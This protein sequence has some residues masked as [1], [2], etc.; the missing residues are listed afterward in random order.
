MLQSGDIPQQSPEESVDDVEEELTPEES[1]RAQKML[2]MAVY[3][4]LGFGAGSKIFEDV[5][6]LDRVIGSLAVSGLIR[7]GAPMVGYGS[8]E[9]GRAG[10]RTVKATTSGVKSFGQNIINGTNS[11]ASSLLRGVGNRVGG[12]RRSVSETRQSVTDR[13]KAIKEVAGV[14]PR[15]LFAVLGPEYF[16]ILDELQAKRKSEADNVDSNNADLDNADSETVAVQT[17]DKIHFIASV[18]ENKTE[19]SDLTDSPDLLRMMSKPGGSLLKIASNFRKSDTQAQQEIRERSV[20]QDVVT[21][22][23]V[24]IFSHLLE[25]FDIAPEKSDILARYLS[26]EGWMSRLVSDES[27]EIHLELGKGFTDFCLGLV[28]IRK[29]VEQVRVPMDIISVLLTEPDLAQWDQIKS[30]LEDDEVKQYLVDISMTLVD[31]KKSYRD[32]NTARFTQKVQEASVQIQ[33]FLRHDFI[34][35]QNIPEIGALGIALSSYI[36]SSEMRNQ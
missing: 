22:I 11:L 6:T 2:V 9:I 14:L 25:I 20:D 8:Q 26:K 34:P 18:A 35:V 13:A 17:L 36:T 4:L 19:W 16:R 32:K 23:D 31:L 33:E 7:T 10:V 28:K 5:N 24:K 30:L 15:V 27:G 1:S 21:E 3:V 29:E 12:V